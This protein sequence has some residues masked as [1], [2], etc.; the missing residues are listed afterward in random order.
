MKKIQKVDA[1]RL[2]NGKFGPRNCAN[3][4]GRPRKPE[5][6]E[7][8]QALEYA[9]KRHKKSFL[10]HFCERAYENDQVAIALAKKIIPDKIEGEGFGDQV[11]AFFQNIKSSEGRSLEDVIAEINNRLSAQFARKR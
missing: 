2:A 1:S 11:T 4:S 8:R 6:E 3:P 10:Q 7:L 5:V 9:Q